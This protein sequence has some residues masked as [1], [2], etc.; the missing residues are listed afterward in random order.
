M[1]TVLS[2]A[3]MAE[4]LSATIHKHMTDGERIASLPLY[5]PITTMM[6]DTV[7]DHGSRVKILTATLIS[8][9]VESAPAL[10]DFDLGDIGGAIEEVFDD[11]EYQVS[12]LRAN[13]AA[14]KA[15]HKSIINN[16][17]TEYAGRKS[18]EGQSEEDVEVDNC[19][20]RRCTAR[21]AAQTGAA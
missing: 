3:I 17:E 5:V 12:Q 15:F 14:D 6:M 20:C 21:R 11:L 18:S 1:E 10:K 2:N 4:K 8:F 19:E 9:V 16:Y 13:L 7:T